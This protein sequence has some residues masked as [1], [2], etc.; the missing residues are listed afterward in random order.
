[1]PVDIG[2]YMMQNITIEK[3]KSILY[4]FIYGETRTGNATLKWQ[5]RGAAT[6]R[7]DN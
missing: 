4:T 2:W 1:M 5:N 6:L 3:R 7:F